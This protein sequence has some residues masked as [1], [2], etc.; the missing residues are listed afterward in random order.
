MAQ[1]AQPKPLWQRDDFFDPDGPVCLI[2]QAT[3]G[4]AAGLDRF[5][6]AGFPEVGHVIYQS[7]DRDKDKVCIVDSAAS[8]AN[9]L[10]QVCLAGDNDPSLHPDLT[11]LPYVKCV[12]DRREVAANAIEAA[13]QSQQHELVTTSLLIG[14]RIGS[15][16]F[17]H[18]NDKPTLLDGENKGQ[19]FRDVLRREFAIRE[20]KPNTTYFVPPEAW[21]SIFKTLFQYDPNSLIHGVLFAREQIK[22]GRM[23]TAHLEAH[24]AKRWGSS[25]VMFNT[26]KAPK[27]DQPIFPKEDV[28]SEKGIHATF[29]IDLGILRSYGRDAKGEGQQS[30]GLSRQQKELLL[31]LAVWKVRQL[32]RRTFT[33]RSGCKLAMTEVKISTDSADVKDLPAEL[34]KIDMTAVIGGAGFAKD[35]R[36]T[37][38]YYPF[39]ELFKPGKEEKK[40]AGDQEEDSSDDSEE[41]GDQ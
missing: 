11:G 25:G 12:T 37:S 4:I 14:H 38:V 13:A 2:I 24:G 26:P 39:D 21:W 7:P 9:H 16:Y 36:V 6:P 20:V 3:M 19:V 5:Q 15:E 29:V 23:L 30:L 1:D 34:P 41:S 22:I 10:E 18:P 8:M 40:D 17:V 33:Y 35:P 27:F 28:T 32:L 31:A